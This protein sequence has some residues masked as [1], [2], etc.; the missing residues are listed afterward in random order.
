M[1]S[2]IELCA[3]ICK[4]NN[5]KELKWKGDKSLIGQIDKQN[6]TV[7]RWFK[8][9]ACP[10]EFL[11]ERHGYIAAEV[12]KRLGVYSNTSNSSSSTQS[13]ATTT[14]LY[15]VRKSWTDI[16]SQTGAYSSLENAKKNC[17]S[18]YSVFDKDGNCVY[19]NVPQT[20]TSTK[21]YRVQ[22]GSFALEKNAIALQKRLKK[23]GFDSIIKKSGILYKVQVGAYSKKDNAE[24]MKKKLQAKGFNAFIVYS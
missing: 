23:A 10:G 8:S 17:K 24:E 15:R 6:M 7:H 3:D 5:I 21:L 9:K 12:N 1:K 22:T 4:R 11:Y 13:P 16:S 18:G 2:L 14:N 20:S 19:S